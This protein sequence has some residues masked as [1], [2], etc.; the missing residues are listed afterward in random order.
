MKNE[1]RH[2]AKV[3]KIA[4]LTADIKHFWLQVQDGNSFDFKAG[5]FVTLDLPIGEH[6]KDRLRSYSIASSPNGN[7]VF[8]LVIMHLKGGRASEYLFNEIIEGDLINFKG[9]HGKFLL[10]EKIESDICFV[11]TGT[12]I[13]PFRSML[14]HLEKTNQQ[15]KNIFLFFGTRFMKDVLFREEME[16]LQKAFPHFNYRFVLSKEESAEYKGAKGHIH[17]LYEN[18][19]ADKRP[20]DFYLC[21]WRGMI[22]EAKIRLKTMDYS[23]KNIHQ[24]IYD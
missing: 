15:H 8:E 21:G 10:P 20:A 3:I 2:E 16:Q 6:P 4:E 13:T 9:P 24:E 7:Y 14:Q 18:E 17:Q 11:C 12:G 5:Q 22:D 23:S 1:N 19:F